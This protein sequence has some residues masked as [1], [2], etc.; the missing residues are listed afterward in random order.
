M[1]ALRRGRPVD[2]R[3]LPSIR[4]GSAV[5]GRPVA[6]AQMQ[7]CAGVGK[8]GDCNAGNVATV[9]AVRQRSS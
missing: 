3:E 6:A 5:D 1:Q 2:E 4:G 8:L 7:A 9:I